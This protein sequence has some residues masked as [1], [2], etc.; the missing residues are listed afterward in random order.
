MFDL[1][2]RDFL[3]LGLTSGLTY[4]T[5]NPMREAVA[6]FASP[7]NLIEHPLRRFGGS[8]TNPDFNGD[9]YQ[10]A[11]ERIWDL[12]GYIKARGGR[13]SA[14]SEQREVVVVGGGIA[15]LSSAYFLQ[16]KNPIVLEQ[17]IQFGGNSKGEVFGDSPFSIGA[18]Y[19]TRPENNGPIHRMLQAT[20]ILGASRLDEFGGENVISKSVGLKSFWKGDSDPA[21][22][23]L[24]KRIAEDLKQISLKMYPQIPWNPNSISRA[25]FDQLDRLTFLQWFQSRYGQTLPPSLLE[26]MQ[27]YCW[28]S[29]GGSFDEISATQGL[30]FLAGEIDGLVAFPGGNAAIAQGLYNYLLGRLAPNS[31][32]SGSMVLEVKTVGN[33]VEILVDPPRGNLYTIA[34]RNCVIALPKF[35]AQYIVP[36]MSVVQ[37]Q[38]ARS[39][40][41]RGYIVSNVLLKA[42]L[43]SPS[44]D[45]FLVDG[46]VPPSPRMTGPMTRSF[47]DVCF[48]NWASQDRGTRSILT[49]Y[50]AFP[51]DGGKNAML[52]PSIFA[53]MREESKTITAEILTALKVSTNAIEGIRMSRWG[54]AL[55]LAQTGFLASHSDLTFKTPTNDRIFYANQDND[56]NPSFEA[57]FFNA[58]IAAAQ[59]L[60][61][62]V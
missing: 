26:F 9:S 3:R 32:R 37:K 5:F 17:D 20:G 56:A 10:R 52:H 1:N 50:K 45:T 25:M 29:F 22:A 21:N 6:A 40:K 33:T 42:P 49:L 54:H 30:N 57:A 48:A 58:E 7:G 8:F 28:S 14:P 4:L 24:Y 18:A 38:V 47:S 19:I 61:S 16:S 43:E 44:L 41:Y 15:G 55:P 35:V 12:A 53:R 34:C 39:M 23:A 31:L 2:R 46:T 11:H 27:L 62:N 59:I 13:P 51:Y 36:E 60:R